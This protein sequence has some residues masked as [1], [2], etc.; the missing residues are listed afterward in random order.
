MTRGPHYL[1]PRQSVV[2]GYTRRMLDETA[3]NANTF[4]MA[5]A[6]LYLQRTAPD[7]RTVPLRL[8]G[9]DDLIKAMKANGQTLRRYMDG[10]VKVLPADLEDAWVLAL[11][12][13]YRS[14]CERDLASR[15]GRY[16]TPHFDAPEGR[17]PVGMGELFTE[18]G[19]LCEA[20]APALAD[21]VICEK[22]LPHAH[23]ILRKSDGLIS[24]VLGIRGPVTELLADQGERHAR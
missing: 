17:A 14:D 9:G 3:T 5:V 11:P 6:E 10:T 13:P 22:D 23:A 18:F 7:V 2:Y 1:P 20:L 8:G 4:A 16:S 24:A 15:R 21:G 12:E 19:Q